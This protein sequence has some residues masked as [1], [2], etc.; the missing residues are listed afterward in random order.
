LKEKLDADQQ[1]KFY[2]K[3]N[4]KDKS[5]G[6]L[7]EVHQAFVRFAEV[8]TGREIIF[9]AQANSGKQYSAEVVRIRPF[10]QS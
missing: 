9:L 10:F 2:L 1:S 3:F 7:L 5:K 4:V 6:S 8:K